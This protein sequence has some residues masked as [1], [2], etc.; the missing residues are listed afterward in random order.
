M[1]T[2]STSNKAEVDNFYKTAIENQIKTNPRK[3]L[4]TS[5][6]T[7]SFKPKS[8]DFSLND[9]VICERSIRNFY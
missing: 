7:G 4:R 2:R 9:S 3:T 8:N 6:P 1:N 5:I